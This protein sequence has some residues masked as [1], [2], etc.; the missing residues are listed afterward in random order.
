VTRTASLPPIDAKILVVDDHPANLLVL[1][2]TLAPLGHTV[3]KA[4]SGEEALRELLHD[5]FA[6]ILMD[7]QMP[8]IDGFQAAQMIKE[9]KRTRHIPIIFVTAIHREA[10]HIFKGYSHGAVDYLLKPFD[11]DILRSKVAVFVDL[12]CKG[13][14]I[15]WQERQLR[16][17]ALQAEA[18]RSEQRFRD[19]VDGL[20]LCAWAAAADGRIRYANRMARALTEPWE[21]GRSDALPLQLVHEDDR[22]RAEQSWKQAV[23]TA[24]QVE[25]EL[26]L[27]LGQAYRWHLMRAV[28]ERDERGRVT[29]WIATATDIDDRKRSDEDRA[30]RLEAER[31]AREEAEAANRAKDE[32]LATVSHELRTPLNAILGWARMLSSGMLDAARMEHAIETIERNAQVQTEL[33]EDILD[34][35]RIVTGKMQ[36]HIRPVSWATLVKAAVDTVRPTAEAKGVALR[37][38]LA[39]VPD[40]TTG[41][42]ERL[43]QVVWNLLSNAIKFTPPGGVVEVTLTQ[44][45]GAVE[46][47]VQDSGKGIPQEFLP[48]VF[49]RFSQADGIST[50]SHGGLGL[51]L[52]IVRNLVEQHGGEVAAESQGEG[53]GARFIV[54]VPERAKGD[55]GAENDWVSAQS[56]P[57]PTSLQSAPTLQDV[58]VLFVDDQEDA[59]E[60]VSEL[61]EIYGAKVT[62]VGTVEA[63]L[64][65]LAKEV[66]DVLISDIGLPEEDGYS[67][68]RR[69]RALP[70]ERGGRVPAIAVTGFARA[71]DG[72]R[73]LQDGFQMHLAKPVEPSELLALVRSLS[74]AHRGIGEDRRPEEL[75]R[76]AH[77][78]GTA[79]YP[80]DGTAAQ[81]RPM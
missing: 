60:L 66:P 36:L 22:A 63:A 19:L 14:R 2:A 68:I 55:E 67:L 42:P 50:R 27:R 52:A 80:S 12:Y 6:V 62:A 49:E 34:V 72:K 46:V 75:G 69:I 58:R 13:E 61:L 79:H 25:L 51:G 54:K 81:K 74:R 23:A 11:A 21:E 8:G 38:Q 17:Q 48:R 73:A 29:G 59:R 43:Q 18:Q 44:A 78:M 39:E 70:P 5:D 76:Q 64:A 10:P 77:A 41:D 26:R 47:A 57:P 9:R 71:E 1:E 20:P 30:R 3:V 31:Q 37:A 15:K 7:V 4:S 56:Q 33:I 35:A 65:A 40:G 24:N 16:E 45:E 28:P 53:K 32:F